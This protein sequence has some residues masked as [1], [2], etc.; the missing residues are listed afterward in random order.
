[1]DCPSTLWPASPRSVVEWKLLQQSGPNHLG[2]GCR[3]NLAHWRQGAAGP[4]QRLE[5]LVRSVRRFAV[6]HAQVWR[7]TQEA[8]RTEH[9][10]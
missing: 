8:S 7:S 5:K 4:G 10:G 9:T 2:S 1:M 3:S 6:V